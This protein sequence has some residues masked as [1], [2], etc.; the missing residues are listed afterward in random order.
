MDPIDDELES[1]CARVF[2]QDLSINKVKLD[3]CPCGGQ[4]S[5]DSHSINY[6]CDVCSRVSLD[7]AA[8][9]D[10]FEA[11]NVTYSYK[12]NIVGQ[13]S[14]AFRKSIHKSNT[15]VTAEFQK[16]KMYHEYCAYRKQ[17]MEAGGRSF[18]M[19]VCKIA[20][21]Y[22]NS[23]QVQCVKRS[24]SKKVI[25]AALLRQALIMSG[26]SP[27]KNEIASFMQLPNKG[28]A[29]G[30]NFVRSFVADGKMDIDLD[31][32][33]CMPEITS[34]FAHIQF[35][36]PEYEN[37]KQCVY[38]VINV[39]IKNQIG[40]RSILRSKVSGATFVVINRRPGCQAIPI[41][42]I[43]DKYI[44]KNTIDRFIS[45]MNSYHSYFKP[46]YKKYGLNAEPFL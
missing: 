15:G 30:A 25:M 13:N 24:H 20:A 6:V 40:T 19:D 36:G 8:A 46:C 11:H 39:A 42:V 1:I 35:E 3:I 9:E 31:I 29:K 10:G 41:S 28:M 22:Y 12:F 4:M 38:D 43:C 34:I 7:G 23:V 16:N 18:P 27:S 33:P 44:R 37:L 17:Y 5:H 26:F 45:E 2:G 14:I 32:D 21:D